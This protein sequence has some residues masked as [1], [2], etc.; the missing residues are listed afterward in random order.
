MV[1]ASDLSL[2]FQTL[3]EPFLVLSEIENLVP[4]H[5][6]CSVTQEELTEVCDSG[7]AGQ[8]V[9]SVA[10]LTFGEYVRLLEKARTVGSI[11][12]RN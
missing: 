3:T 1:I 6:W 7:A 9:A 11:A 8:Q 4:E 2:Q 5:D 12:S 10:D